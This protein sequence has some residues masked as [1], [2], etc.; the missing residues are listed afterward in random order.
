MPT[1]PNLARG[2]DVYTSPYMSKFS[3]TMNSRLAFN[4]VF[5]FSH[6][7]KPFDC[8]VTLQW[9]KLNAPG[10]RPS[11][12]RRQC[13][14]VVGKKVYFFGGTGPGDKTQSTG[15][16]DADLIDRSDL[17]VLDFGRYLEVVS[18]LGHR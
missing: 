3:I 13:A 18:S 11:P 1:L 6:F 10:K 8:A 14:C 12:R 15:P 17:F 9:R 5:F 7:P 4:L 2:D 16:S